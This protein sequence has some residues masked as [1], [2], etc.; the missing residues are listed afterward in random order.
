MSLYLSHNKQID[1][2]TQQ[3]HMPLPPA[4][5]TL[6]DSLFWTNPETLKCKHL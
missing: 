2:E 4:P 1:M 6:F 3:P 5:A